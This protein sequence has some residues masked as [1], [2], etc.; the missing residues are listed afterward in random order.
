MSVTDEELLALAAVDGLLP[1]TDGLPDGVVLVSCAQPYLA[2]L[3]ARRLAQALVPA[4]MR[5]HDLHQAVP[6]TGRW[7]VADVEERIARPAGLRPAGERQVILVA[8]ADQM[9]AGTADRLLK[10][11]EEPGH[12]TVFVL[13]CR[14]A[15][16]LADT[17]RSR[18]MRHL[19]VPELDPERLAAVLGGRGVPAG[20][21]A[22]AF[23]ARTPFVPHVLGL[24]ADQARPLCDRLAELAAPAAGPSFTAAEAVA[25]A[26]SAAAAALTGK[27]E[28][29][30]D[31]KAALRELVAAHLSAVEAA[32]VRR[33]VQAATA[34][35]LDAAE[36]ALRQA[37]RARLALHR[38]API[39]PALATLYTSLPAPSGATP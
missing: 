1:E 17:I 39:A 5:A 26:A 29:H 28:R 7:T 37:A 27:G 4:R 6:E 22:A 33:L 9:S 2:L 19:R 38:H 16:G 11:L 14:D 25:A 18:A 24:P 21:A 35:D 30:P 36:R 20:P 31:T 12:G 32:Q 3:V 34:D 8:D 10:P 23:L 13:A 15:D